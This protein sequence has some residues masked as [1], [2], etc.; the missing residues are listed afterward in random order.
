MPHGTTNPEA[1]ELFSP[2]G[3]AFK[4]GF[5]GIPTSIFINFA[6]TNVYISE[7]MKNLLFAAFVML[8]LTCSCTD[9][10]MEAATIA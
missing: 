5:N 10:N 7:N 6:A 3:F 9:K 8:A 2:P 1:N 4:A